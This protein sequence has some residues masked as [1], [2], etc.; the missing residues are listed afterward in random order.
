MNLSYEDL[1]PDELSLLYLLSIMFF[2]NFIA[3][4][5]NSLVPIIIALGVGNKDG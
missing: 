1:M 2:L 3:L 5:S 4:T